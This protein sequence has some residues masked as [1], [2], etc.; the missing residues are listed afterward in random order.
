MNIRTLSV[1]LLW[2]VTTAAAAAAT[3]ELDIAYDAGSNEVELQWQ[4]EP[5]ASYRIYNSGDLQNWTPLT[6]VLVGTGQPER[7]QLQA[8]QRR[9]FFVLRLE[10]DV[11]FDITGPAQTPIGRIAYAAD[12]QSIEP[13]LGITWSVDSANAVVDLPAAT[14]THIY[15]FEPGEYTVSCTV[16]TACGEATEERVVTASLTAG[17]PSDFAAAPRELHATPDSG[18]CPC[19]CCGSTMTIRTTS[20]TIRSRPSRTRGT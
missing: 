6:G 19:P 2:F 10:C 4:G 5:G 17:S 13:V 16:T 9:H 12:I 15:F 11:D 20:P 1:L 18:P 3:L 7:I 14:N 8:P